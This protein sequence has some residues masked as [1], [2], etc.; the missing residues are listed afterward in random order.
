MASRWDKLG[1]KLERVRDPLGFDIQ[2]RIRPW[3]VHPDLRPQ[4]RKENDP[5]DDDDE[6][7]DDQDGDNE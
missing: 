5:K 4:S 2:A 6:D 1:Q 7:D 3:T